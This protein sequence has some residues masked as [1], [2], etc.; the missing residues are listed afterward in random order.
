MRGETQE[1]L[2]RIVPELEGNGDM[3]VGASAAFA[4]AFA[5]ASA[6]VGCSSVTSRGGHSPAVPRHAA[7]TTAPV[8]PA[9]DPGTYLEFGVH[10]GRG[11]ATVGTFIPDGPIQVRW[12]CVGTG[13]FI[14]RLTQ[15][16][17]NDIASTSNLACDGAL[18]VDDEPS[19]CKVPTTLEVW[20]DTTSRW[21][22]EVMSSS[23]GYAAELCHAGT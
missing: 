19:E 3:K 5:F 21:S 22:V 14:E 6:A 12:V 1:G 18:H 13:N 8:L 11:N 7:A 4:F 23:T 9:V 17:G 16:G 15:S 20:S 2:L 10:E